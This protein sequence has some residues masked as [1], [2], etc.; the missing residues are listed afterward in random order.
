MLF[1][2]SDCE[3]MSDRAPWPRTFAFGDFVRL[4]HH[5]ELWGR[6][7]GPSEHAGRWVFEYPG[8]A[9]V[10]NVAE[11]FE[12]FEPT[13]QQRQQ[14]DARFAA[15]AARRAPPGPEWPEGVSA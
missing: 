3:L 8:G 2:S 9:R 14:T 10:S 7:V 13:A 5:P 12:L 11:A 6:I 1:P 4:T 15:L